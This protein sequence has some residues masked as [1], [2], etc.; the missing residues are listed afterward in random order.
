M[1]G[2]IWIGALLIVLALCLAIQR[3]L[4]R[5]LNDIDGFFGVHKVD[6]SGLQGQIVGAF[7]TDEKQKPSPIKKKHSVKSIWKVHNKCRNIA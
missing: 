7:G 2:N 6:A 1:I 3:I 5:K 4:K